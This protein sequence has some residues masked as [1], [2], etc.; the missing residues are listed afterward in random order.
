MKISFCSIQRKKRVAQ[1]RFKCPDWKD[2]LLSTSTV[3]FTLLALYSRLGRVALA[4]YTQ[5]SPSPLTL[6]H[7]PILQL[8]L[9]GTLQCWQVPESTAREAFPHNHSSSPPQTPFSDLRYNPPDNRTKSNC[10][11]DACSATIKPVLGQH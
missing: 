1:L 6:R 7:G 8:F 9:R 10:M 11:K 5:V 4:V 3:S 2:A